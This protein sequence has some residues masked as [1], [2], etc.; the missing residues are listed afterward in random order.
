MQFGFQPFWTI[1]LMG[2]HMG[3]L[4]RRSFL[5]RILLAR[6]EGRRVRQA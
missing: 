6:V 5:S 2:A 1:R 3:G 4:N